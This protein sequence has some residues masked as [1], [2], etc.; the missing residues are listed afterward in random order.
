M[1]GVV[2]FNPPASHYFCYQNFSMHY[3]Y[4]F[5]K[6]SLYFFGGKIACRHICI[7]AIPTRV[8]LFVLH[9]FPMTMAQRAMCLLRRSIGFTAPPAQRALSTTATPAAEGAVVAEATVKEAKRRKK[10][11]LFDVVQFLPEWGIG[12]KVAKTTWRDVSY[13]ITKINLYKVIQ[14]PERSSCALPLNFYL[15]TSFQSICCDIRN[16]GRSA[17]K[18]VG[19]SLQGRLV[20]TPSLHPLFL[21]S[22]SRHGAHVC[23]KSYTIE[24]CL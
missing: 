12:Y 4:L 23:K 7:G 10:K 21:T 2:Y 22:S 16:A 15:C 1:A 9:R 11:N 18:G 3:I 5:K 6:I 19:D 24:E 14:S 20:F 13:Q 8:S 17:W